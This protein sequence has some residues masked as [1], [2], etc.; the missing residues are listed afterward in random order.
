MTKAGNDLVVEN[1]NWKFDAQVVEVFDDHVSKS[2]PLYHETHEL[3]ASISDFF[4]GDGS[5]AY[6]LGSST[7][8]LLSVIAKRNQHKDIRLVGIDSVDSMVAAAEQKCAPYKSISFARDDILTFDYEKCDMIFSFYT[9]QF[10]RPQ[11]RQELFDRL[12]EALNW[13]GAMLIL[14]KVRAPDA[15]FQDMM[16]SIYHDYKLSR[17]FSAEEVMG[18]ANSL[19]G[20]LEPFSTQGNLDLM[21]RA[22]FV[23]IMSVYK[24]VC[25]EAFLAIK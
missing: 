25:W 23:D 10:V 8:Q 12:Y 1:A 18:K 14:E 24:W 9:I 21:K 15:R 2:V 17:G 19:R 7:G 11:K 13:G 20:V 4:I 5:V 3:A 22:G 6:E 16:T